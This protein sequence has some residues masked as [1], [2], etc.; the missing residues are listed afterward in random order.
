MSNKKL[1]SDK[2]EVKK[3]KEDEQHSYT[4]DLLQS[5]IDD[6]AEEKKASRKK[7]WDKLLNKK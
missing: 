4:V 6:K 5:M 1:I 3:T 2:K 7:Q